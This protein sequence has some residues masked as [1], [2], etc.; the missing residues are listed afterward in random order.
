MKTLRATLSTVLSLLVV[1]PIAYSIS[2]SFFQYTDFTALPPRLLPSSLNISN[3][4]RA[5]SESSLARFLF[6]SLLTSIVGTL[7]RMAIS[8][9]AAYTFSFFA[10]KGRNALF[11][12]IVA[13]MLLP[14]DALIIANFMTIRAL[15]LT[16]TYMGIIATSLLAPTHIFMLRQYFRMMSVEY[17]EAAIIEGCTDSRFLTTLLI[18]MSKAVI[19]TLAIH[20]FSTIFND[21]LWPLL[22]TNKT[23]M[24]TVQVGLTMMGFSEHLDY[25]PQFAA[26]TFLMTPILIAFIALHK[27]IIESVSIR[28][29]GR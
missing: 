9:M 14:S 24:R 26:I 21:Y 1:F 3:Y 7:L 6:N 11:I 22:V 8:I 15:R 5:F 20:S 28:F 16:D 27:P 4:I 2:A 10:F 17:R 18:P 19:L 29:T 23:S 13:T 12:L 25:G